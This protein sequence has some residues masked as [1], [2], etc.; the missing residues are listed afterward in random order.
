MP[1][2]EPAIF[3]AD[4]PP[5]ELFDSFYPFIK[6]VFSQWHSTPFQIDGRTIVTAEQWMMFS[7]A[8]LFGD[9]SAASAILATDSPDEQKRFGQTVHGFQQETW[10]RWKVS[11]VYQGNLAKFSQNAGAARQLKATGDAMLVE[12]NPRDWIWGV[13]L[14]IDDPSVHSPAEW[15]GGNLLGRILTKVRSDLS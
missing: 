12:A 5:P 2:D 13:G 15:K 10:D 4:L 6:G 3:E 1:L 11:F 9:D 7:K 8:R 14:A